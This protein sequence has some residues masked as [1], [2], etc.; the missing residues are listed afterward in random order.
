MYSVSLASKLLAV[1]VVGPVVIVAAF[2]IS[3]TNNFT[4]SLVAAGGVL[5]ALGLGW[6]F[7]GANR[8][9]AFLLAEAL[10]RVVLTLLAVVGLH[11]GGPLW[12]YALS[13]ALGSTVAF[14]LGAIIARLPIRPRGVSGGE[15]ADAVKTQAVVVVGR[16]IA[17]LYTTLPVTLLGLV[18]P[19]Q[20]AVFSAT[21]RPL[22]MG[23]MVIAG[24]PNRLQSWIG[25][26][27]AHVGR[28]RSIKSIGLNSVLGVIAGGVFLTAG[29]IVIPILFSGAIEPGIDLYLLGAAIVLLVCTSRGLGLALVA[30]NRAPAITEAIAG[31]AVTG[32]AGVLILGAL[33]GAGGALAAVALAEAVGVL[34]QIVRFRQTGGPQFSKGTR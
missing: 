16:A 12:L 9:Y 3:P 22:R 21:D 13:V 2:L 33:F 11:L 4:S 24:V 31:A 15:V 6:I 8:P 25:H 14:V 5:S 7:I 27:D 1:A 34:W 30:A 23:L 26:P 28:A 20:I 17:S 29:P 10:P 19:T 32:V 18:N